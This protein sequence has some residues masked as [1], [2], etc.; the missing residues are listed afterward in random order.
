[1]Q[2]NP[3]LQE[4]A[5]TPRTTQRLHFFEQ[6]GL[7]LQVEPLFP[8]VPSAARPSW[9][10]PASGGWMFPY[11]HFQLFSAQAGMWAPW[12]RARGQGHSGSRDAGT[13]G[14]ECRDGS[15]HHSQDAGTQPG[16]PVP[17]QSYTQ[18]RIFL[19]AA[20]PLASG[21]TPEVRKS[22]PA[23]HRSPPTEFLQLPWELSPWGGQETQGTSLKYRQLASFSSK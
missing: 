2:E 13:I 22:N 17:S 8:M 16:L 18:T 20:D 15:I 9:R 7:L 3:S 19:A 4:E 14:A 10:A 6:S 5:I 11:R 1:M 12:S 21:A 23:N